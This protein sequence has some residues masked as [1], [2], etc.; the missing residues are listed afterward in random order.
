MKN[1]QIVAS[2]ARL[3]VAF[4]ILS[5]PR[6]VNHPVQLRYAYA[7]QSKVVFNRVV[8]SCVNVGHWKGMS[9]DFS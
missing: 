1:G 4:V 9:E 8:N 3:A 2:C 5:S 7:V 6:L